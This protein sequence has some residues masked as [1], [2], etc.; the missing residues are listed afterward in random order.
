M[1]HGPFYTCIHCDKKQ[2]FT[3]KRGLVE[4]QQG[5]PV[6]GLCQRRYSRLDVL[7]LLMQNKNHDKNKKRGNKVISAIQDFFTNKYK[8]VKYVLWIFCHF[9]TKTRIPS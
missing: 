1:N 4:H 6:C 2:A 9:S 3:D 7:K 5:D 8:G